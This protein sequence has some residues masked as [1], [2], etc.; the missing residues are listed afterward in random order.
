MQRIWYNTKSMSTIKRSGEQGMVSFLVTLIMM[1]VIT[2]IVVGFSEV[3]RHNSRESLDRQLSAQAFYAAES[4]IN[5]TQAAIVSY[6]NANGSAGLVAKTTCTSD[7]D[8]TQAGGAASGP[9]TA[10]STK[11]GYTCVLV[12]PTPSTLQ[13]PVSQQD[14]TVMP[15]TANANLKS[16]TLSWSEQDGGSKA[17]CTG[18]LDG[19]FSASTV[20]GTDCDFGLLRLD[21][22]ANPGSTVKNAA[23]LVNNTVSVFL[24][25]RGTHSGTTSVGFGGA[26]T[27]YIVSGLDATSGSGACTSG[28]C[29]AT[30]TLPDNTASYQLRATTLYKDAK[31]V[32]VS[33]VSDTGPATFSGSQ[34]VVDV[35][36]Q[37]QDELRRVQARVSLFS[38][39][40]NIPANAIAS[41]HD[42][43]K[44][45]AILPTDTI[46]FATA[47]VCS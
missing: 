24:T 22:V 10:L 19:Q 14:S 4:G 9:I 42:I 11:V 6:V 32:V 1:M 30:I 8:P 23:T 46:D 12:N 34:A 36:G 27:A 3:T 26:T 33:G 28:V 17:T 13:F 39:G 43:C 16:L 44:H 7:Y 37:D 2:L 45:F 31:S 15:I 41:S 25:P 29:K 35:T 20:W 18:A 47:G 40:N 38:S 5:V 21:L